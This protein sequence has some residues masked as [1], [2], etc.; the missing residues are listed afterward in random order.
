MLIFIGATRCF[1][2]MGF[3]RFPAAKLSGLFTI[4]FMAFS[5]IRTGGG[6]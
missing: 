5:T 1:G 4:E 6:V 3:R 2:L